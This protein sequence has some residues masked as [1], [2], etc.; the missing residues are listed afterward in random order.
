MEYNY[1]LKNRHAAVI[2]GA[3]GIGR[4]V[5]I[6]FARHG[7]EVVV[8]DES[9]QAVDLTLTEVRSYSPGSVSFII[10]SDDIRPVCD[11]AV[12][13][14]GYIDILVNAG[15]IYQTGSLPEFKFDDLE[16]MLRVNLIR[17]ITAVKAFIPGMKEQRRGD[18]INI[19][20]DLATASRP[21]TSAIAACAG[22][23]Y[24]FTRSVTIDYIRYNIRANCI[25][26][27]FDQLPGRLP[28]TGSPDVDDVANAALFYACDLSRNIIGEP[29]PVNGGMRYFPGLDNGGI[30]I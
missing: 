14:M 29:M 17:Q 5:S 15:G 7:A 16:R 4:A 24:A 30:A 2:G 13:E 6:L 26:C 11:N 18:I 23:I 27:P 1:L 25:L 10:D 22:A 3:S 12:N 8:I 9:K 19:T 20:S 28:L 21:D